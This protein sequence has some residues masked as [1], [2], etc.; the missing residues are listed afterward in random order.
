MV[1][2]RSKHELLNMVR[3]RYLEARTA[4]PAASGAECQ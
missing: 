1:S 3:S 4:R 2:Y